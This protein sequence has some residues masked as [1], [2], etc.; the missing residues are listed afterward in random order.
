MKEGFHMRVKDHSSFFNQSSTE[1]ENTYLFTES[2]KG[3]IRE[4]KDQAMEL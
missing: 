4:E 2:L 1:D 3:K